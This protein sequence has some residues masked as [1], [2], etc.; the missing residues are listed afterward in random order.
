[1]SSI[2]E[3]RPPGTLAEGPTPECHRFIEAAEATRRAQFA[4]RTLPNPPGEKTVAVRRVPPHAKLARVSPASDRLLTVISAMRHFRRLGNL[5][6][7]NTTLPNPLWPQC[8]TPLA[9]HSLL[10]RKRSVLSTKAAT[11]PAIPRPMPSPTLGYH[12]LAQAVQP[13]FHHGS[14]SSPVSIAAPLRLLSTWTRAST[15]CRTV[16]DFGSVL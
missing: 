13:A 1:M 6:G 11:R 4:S 10:Q 5:Q 7:L 15:P 9:I 12:P 3:D 16:A 8:S 14:K 2:L